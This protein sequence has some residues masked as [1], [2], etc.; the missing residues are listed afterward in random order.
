MNISIK[1]GNSAPG[2]NDLA[3]YQLGYAK[4]TEGLY[5]RDPVLN[6]IIHLNS[7]NPST[8]GNI[9]GNIK[10]GSL[11]WLNKPTAQTPIAVGE[12]SWYLKF[13]YNA[14]GSSDTGYLHA[15]ELR[16]N[17]MAVLKIEALESSG[18]T[19]AKKIVIHNDRFGDLNGDSWGSTITTTPKAKSLSWSIETTRRD[20]GELGSGRTNVYSNRVAFNSDGDYS[21][22]DIYDEQP[23]ATQSPEASTMNVTLRLFET[24]N[25][26][27]VYKFRIIGIQS[28]SPQI[29][30][31]VFD[32]IWRINL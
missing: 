26:F 19:Y 29:M 3:D 22:V 27:T 24:D 13:A 11:Q 28:A 15:P 21:Y 30:I 23:T 25:I 14:N 20:I 17:D 32:S 7:E 5:I 31:L 6:K 2:L 9:D 18:Q 10:A 1:R 16:L 12:N 8:G 4:N